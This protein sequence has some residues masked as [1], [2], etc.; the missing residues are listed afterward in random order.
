[1]VDPKLPFF[2]LTTCLLIKVI[3]CKKER[4]IQNKTTNIT[5]IPTGAIIAGKYI[6]NPKS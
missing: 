5:K 1:M 6:S 2:K 4:I 3:G